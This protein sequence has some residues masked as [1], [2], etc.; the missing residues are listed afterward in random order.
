MI[1]KSPKQIWKLCA[2]CSGLIG[3]MVMRVS[4][5][6]CIK[7]YSLPFHK[8]TIFPQMISDSYNFFS[9]F[10]DSLRV[11]QC[12]LGSLGFLR[13]SFYQF[14]NLKGAHGLSPFSL[15]EQCT[16]GSRTHQFFRR[17]AQATRGASNSLIWGRRR[18]RK[19]RRRG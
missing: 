9:N 18:R 5:K 2:R 17:P 14:L 13:I 10:F 4:E 12:F 15:V 19:R 7:V 6:F 1:S 3:T 16:V 11:P 8:K